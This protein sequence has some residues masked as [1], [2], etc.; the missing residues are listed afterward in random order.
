MASNV[1]VFLNVLLHDTLSLYLHHFHAHVKYHP[2]TGHVHMHII[3]IVTYRTN[4]LQV[5]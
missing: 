1:L 2:V 4:T 5:P 3:E